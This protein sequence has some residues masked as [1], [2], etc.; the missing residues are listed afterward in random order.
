MNTLLDFGKRILSG[1]W[2]AFTLTRSVVLNTI[3]IVFFIGF[4]AM[5]VSDGNKITVPEKTALVLNLV[6]DLVEQKQEVSPMDAFLTN[7]LGEEE[8]R[9]EVLLANVLDVIAQA[10]NDDRVEILVLQLQGLRSAGLTKLQDVGVALTDFKSSGKTIIALGDQY[11]QEQYYIASYADD[12]WIS[13][14]FCSFVST[15]YKKTLSP[16]F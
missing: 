10:K 11:T 8:E 14:Y 6:G 5:L 12:I 15:F 4:I 13:R 16:R 1:I 2:R 3:F 7:A 9:P